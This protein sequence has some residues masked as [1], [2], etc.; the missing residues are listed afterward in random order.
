MLQD[1]PRHMV[2]RENKK[3]Q[4]ARHEV[5]LYAILHHSKQPLPSK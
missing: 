4:E 3:T 2:K 5:S 1:E